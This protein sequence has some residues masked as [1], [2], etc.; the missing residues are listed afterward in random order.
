MNKWFMVVLALVVASLVG[1]FM[2]FSQNDET[3]P[4]DNQAPTNLELTEADHVIG[5]KDAKV[6]LI[7]YGDFQCP[8]CKA[9]E[10]DVKKLREEYQDK[11]RFVFR[12]F[13]LTSIHPNAFP[14]SRAAEAA[15]S[16]GKFWEMHDLL[17]QRQD[18]WSKSNSAQA[19]L[20]D[21]AR[22]LGISEDQYT[23]GYNSDATTKRINGDVDSGRNAGATGTPAFFL[24]GEL[25][26]PN[27]RSYQE[28]KAKI[29]ALLAQN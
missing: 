3:D 23:N 1:V 18:E 21:Y 6:T 15:G 27:P 22:E 9:I 12:H 29:D 8:A 2:L 14:A 10:P 16:V 13:P 5:N 7:E 20:R 24:N 11:V 28:L 17:Y 19:L 26:D 4:A 25:L